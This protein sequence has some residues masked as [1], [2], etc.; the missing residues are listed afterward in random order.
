MGNIHPTTHYWV[1]PGFSDQVQ[2]HFLPLASPV[3]SLPM[4]GVDSLGIR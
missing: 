4:M 2:S 3:I 1:I